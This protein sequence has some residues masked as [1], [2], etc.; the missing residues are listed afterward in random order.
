MREGKRSKQKGRR[1]TKRDVR[2]KEKK[3][4]KERSERLRD[5]EKKLRVFWKEIADGKLLWVWHLMNGLH[6]VSVAQDPLLVGVGEKIK[7]E[8]EEE[9]EKRYKDKE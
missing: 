2:S 7:G 9:N 4:E 6:F 1:G 3:G 5:A 8:M